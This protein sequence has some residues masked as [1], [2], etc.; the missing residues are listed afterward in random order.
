MPNIN[1][2]QVDGTN[3]DVIS[4]EI[5]SLDEQ[6][7]GKWVDGKPLYQKTLYY[8]STQYTVGQTTTLAH[9]ISNVKMIMFKDAVVYRSMDQNYQMI[10]D[11]D[12]EMEHWGIGIRNMNSTTFGLWIGDMNSYQMTYDYM[13]I[14][15]KYTKTTD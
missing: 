11:V 2:I 6:V 3:Y 7:I 12:A 5:Y 14:T 13:Y 1:K 8:D 10:P 15:F 9:N 4:P